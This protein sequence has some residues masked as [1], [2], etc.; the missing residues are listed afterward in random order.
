M[1]I[2]LLKSAT[3]LALLLF[4]YHF[5]LEK[6]KM[7]NFNRYYLLGSVFFS[8]LVPLTTFTTYAKPMVV[9]TVPTTIE[10]SFFV[11]NTTPI[12]I[13][14]SIDYS[15]L[16]LVVYVF[17]CVILLFRFGRNLFKIIKKIRQN[18]KVNHGKATLVLV[19]DKILPH[20]FWNFIF[21]NKNDY[22]DGK[23]EAELFTHE[24][25]HVIQKHTFDVLF[26]ELLQAIFWINPLFIFLKKAIQLNHEFLADEK[27]INQ[28]KNP[29]QYQHLLLNKAAW[30]NEYYLA[31]NL[32]YSLTKKRLEMMTTQ[33]SKTTVLLKKLAVIPV[34]VGFIFLFAERVEAQEKEKKG[35][36][37]TISDKE[38]NEFVLLI[39]K[40][41]KLTLKNQPVTVNNLKKLIDTKIKDIEY[42]HIILKIAPKVKPEFK[43]INAIKNE[44]RKAGIYR[45]SFENFT[46]S[47]KP[48]K[49]LLKKEKEA[50][51][52]GK[53]IEVE[54]KTIIKTDT[55][56][57]QT[58][59]TEKQ[60]K[61]YKALI[62]SAKKTNM[63]KQKDVVK[64]QSTY[65]LMSKEQKNS[66]DNINGVIF[67]PPPK[68]DWVYTY[69]SLANRIKRTSKNRKANVIYLKSIYNDK[70]N[71][72]ER[73]KVIAPDN[74]VIEVIEV[75]YSNFDRY[76]DLA[77]QYIENEK[78]TENDFKNIQ[79]LYSLLTKSEKKLMMSPE[80]ITK[81]LDD[82]VRKHKIM[83]NTKKR[84]ENFI[85]EK[86]TKISEFNITVEKNDETI[87][88]K[89]TNGCAWTDVSFTLRKN[90]SQAV[91]KFGMTGISEKSEKSDFKFIM[92]N[93]GNELNL[94]SS[95]GTAWITLN[96]SAENNKMAKLDQFGIELQ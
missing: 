36:I 92:T 56:S 41:D 2:Y 52:N 25:T 45:I 37:E 94:K 59:A 46:I 1:I 3:C 82:L 81:N 17:I 58:A 54:E 78:R 65:K 93:N 43:L 15:Q 8:F 55:I 91:D 61:E 12:F 4:F 22:N 49:I 26:I 69:N 11:E 35:E 60:M 32:N 18:E 39:N 6:E 48:H 76:V 38:M 84:N 96:F 7:H 87:I 53:V 90:K 27:V 29:F 9:N 80:F 66:V 50:N 33:S 19:N 31:S 13:E 63:F 23:I 67:P 5:V 24:L 21:V 20:T 10:D 72:V 70:M 89:C 68:P 74:L 28:Y 71:D 79:S 47:P 86:V 44:L 62:L 88:L 95:K 30:N 51:K 83:M 64:M 85:I 40:G 75:E 77:E 14:E 42:A 16:L 73:S 57:K 34:L